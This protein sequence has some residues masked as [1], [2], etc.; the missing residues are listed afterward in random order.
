MEEHH[1]IAFIGAG[2]IAGSL[3]GGLIADHYPEK[4][5]W[6]TGLSLDRLNYLRESFHINT[7]SH[8]R[9]AARQADILIFAVQPTTLKLVITEL[10]DILREKKPLVISVVTGVSSATI[11]K[12]AE[13]PELS[14]V[15]CM[16]NTPALLRCGTTGLYANPA[17]S[18]KQHALAESILRTIGVILWLEEEEKLNTI[19][20]ISG[21]GPAYFFLMMETI[22]ECAHEM[23]L[24]EEEAQ[25]LTVN[26][27][28][29]AARMALE[30]GK[31]IRTLRHQVTSP[32]GTTEQAIHVLEEGGI[33]DL[34]FKALNAARKRAIEISHLLG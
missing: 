8:N 24:T 27:A 22:S 3:I 11:S 10:K 26:T 21:S 29:G 23:G 16:C 17:V 31:D 33:R 5:V 30:S 34:F 4:K 28:L 6:A 2:N 1:T 12:W 19:T 25:L 14:I 7:T 18:S 32:G 20:A 15:R 13:D 9:E